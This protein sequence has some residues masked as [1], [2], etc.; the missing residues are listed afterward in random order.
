[1]NQ[2]S[3]QSQSLTANNEIVSEPSP[4][5]KKGSLRS[6]LLSGG[7]QALFIMFVWELVEEGIESL[8]AVALSSAMAIFITKALSTFAI[9]TATQG[10]KVCLKKCLLPIVKNL[11]YKEGNDKVNKIKQ[12][13]TWIYANKKSLLGVV[14][15]ALMTI[16]GAGVIDVASL[17]F[18]MVGGV[19][20]TPYLYYAILAVFA[21]IGVTGK[22]F[23]N[24]K[25]FFARKA[26]EK[27]NKEAKAIEKEAKKE[28]ANEKKKANQ[29]Q[30]EQEKAKAKED[31]ENEKKLAKEKAEAEHRAKVEEA[32]AALLANEQKQG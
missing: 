4:N 28:L 18:L 27:A 12:F 30:A 13:F 32:K 21:I 25:D 10:I 31:A 3:K 11:T 7:G 20:L 24:I 8:I 2:L 16:S 5:S 17:D 19:N 14:S 23:E 15:S 6:R 29:T 9:I 1:M 22:G 26:V